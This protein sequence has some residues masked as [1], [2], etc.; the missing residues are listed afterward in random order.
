MAEWKAEGEPPGEL[1]AE[2]AE[3]DRR[4]REA[5]SDD[6]NMPQALVVLNEAVSSPVEGR[7]KYR[8][9]AGWDQVLGLDLERD[10]RE[11]FELPPNVQSLVRERD[12]ARSARDFA[13]SD[14]IRD[15]LHAMGFEVM[16]TPGGTRVRPRD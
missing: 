8:L 1:A 13:R 4:F 10:A 5:V 9:L 2:A 12:E 11:G 14:Q 7:S 6:L 3:L 15:R 16:D